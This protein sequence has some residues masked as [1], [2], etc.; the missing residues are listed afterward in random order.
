MKLNPAHAIF[1]GNMFVQLGALLDPIAPPADLQVLDM[2][3]GEPQQPP[4]KLLIESVLRHNEQWQFYPKATGSPHFTKAVETYIARRW[5]EAADL[6]DQSQIIP[7]PGTRE[8]LHLLGHLVS[9]SKANAAALV[10]NPFYHAWRAGALASGSEIIYLN[11]GANHN[12]LPDLQALEPATLDRTSI[13]FLCS[14][15]NPQGTVMDMDY[16]LAA[17]RL[18]RAHDFLLVMDECYADIWWGSPP[19]GM[20]QA[21]AVLAKRDGVDNSHDPFANIVVLNSLSKRSGAAGLRAGFMVGDKRVVTQYL[22]LVSNGGSLVPTPLLS[23]AADLY[24]DEA[25][26]AD[27]R[28]YYHTNFALVERHL[29]LSPPQGGF[30]LWLKVDDDVQFVKRLMAEQA[31][32]ALPGS[33][34]GVETADGNP[35]A[36]Y[37]RLALVHDAKITNEALG[38]IAKIYKSQV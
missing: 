6:A 11:S 31:V 20:M 5:P 24:N 27:I 38:R 17:L 8:P 23:V 18:A 30:F 25:H 33:F 3:I 13:L 1:D 19:T 29:G 36:G 16:L 14:P 37:V 12:F 28:A 32:R 10:T 26:V 7:V 4:A 22:K 9:G 2:S 21:A 15:T 35:G 34:M